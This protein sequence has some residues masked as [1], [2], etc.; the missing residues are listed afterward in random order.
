MVTWPW[1]SVPE[2]VGLKSEAAQWASALVGHRK[3][4]LR[5]IVVDVWTWITTPC[6]DF[7]TIGR[8]SSTRR[9]WG[10]G[11]GSPVGL[12]TRGRPS[13]GRLVC[14]LHSSMFGQGIQLRV[15]ICRY[16]FTKFNILLRFS[17]VG[18][19]ARLHIW[20]LR[21]VWA[22]IHTPCLDCD[23]HFPRI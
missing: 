16:F 21:S 14:E 17:A 8:R 12:G 23:S 15:R 18:Y 2:A 9:R 1:L 22:W 13:T 19:G 10:T 20:A 4:G 11:R 7:L 3:V 6:S 5:A